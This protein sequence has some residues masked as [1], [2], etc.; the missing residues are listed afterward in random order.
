MSDAIL[1]V[2][3]DVRVVSA[4]QRSLYRDYRIEIAAGPSD[5]LDAIVQT[6]Y[7][8]VVSDLQMPVMNGIE[9]LATVKEISPDTV[10][11]LLT[12]KADLDAAIGAVNEG[13]IFRFL[14]KPCPT[15]LL[16]RTLDAALAQHWLQISEKQVLRETLMGTVAVL[17]KVL[18]TI[19]PEVFGR[20]SRIRF[21]VECLA[22]ELHLPETWEFE[23][24]AML[25][26]I[27]CLSV[28]ASVLDRHSRGESLSQEELYQ[29]LSQA[30][31]GQKL[32][33]E[34][35]RLDAV[36]RIIE[37]QYEDF[38]AHSELSPTQYMVAIG[39]HMLRASHDFDRLIRSGLDADSAV[40]EMGLHESEYNPDV[41]RALQH[42]KH[43]LVVPNVTALPGRVGQEESKE[44]PFR[45]IA[46][47]V[48]R[49]LRS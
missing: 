43:E 21:C 22:A 8:V 47:Q 14:T 10:R 17:V 5:A 3:D 7:A 32:L 41:L 33:H 29:V 25:S 31:V 24:A 38:N 18:S 23:A 26:Q 49:T 12:G 40:V 28:D 34:V 15:D 39:A 27:G 13:S 46:E 36:S 9:L 11:V 16:K 19:R 2:D 6:S 42:I 4:L 44:Q 48:L 20:A 37:R 35:P 1:V 30:Q 45:P